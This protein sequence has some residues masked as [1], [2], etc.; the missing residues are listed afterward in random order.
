MFNAP[1]FFRQP[2]PEPSLS[3]LV[4]V[5]INMITYEY[6]FD[7]DMAYAIK[8]LY[9]MLQVHAHWRDGDMTII[10]GNLLL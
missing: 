3:E 10:E 8:N 4:A 6:P 9:G 7:V 1:T 5:I 2:T